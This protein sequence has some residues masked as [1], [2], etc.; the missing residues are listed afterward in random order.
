MYIPSGVIQK[1]QID[2]IDQ[3]H[4]I[5]HIDMLVALGLLETACIIDSFI[6][7]RSIL[8][9]LFYKPTYRF[10]KDVTLGDN[11]DYIYTL[12]E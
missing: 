11:R 2:Y 8:H 9:S 7:K 3:K 1:H 10:I 5:D 12:L 6:F 4:Q